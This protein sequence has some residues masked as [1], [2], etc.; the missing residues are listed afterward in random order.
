MKESIF[1]YPIFLIFTESRNFKKIF[2]KFKILWLISFLDKNSWDKRVFTDKEMLN[3]YIRVKISKLYIS[4]RVKNIKIV[5]LTTNL[6]HIWNT[7]N[8]FEFEFL[9]FFKKY[10]KYNKYIC[11]QFYIKFKKNKHKKDTSTVWYIFKINLKHI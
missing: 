2:L 1:R 4:L 5:F 3:L 6:N 8:K 10:P 11:I 9:L 7:N